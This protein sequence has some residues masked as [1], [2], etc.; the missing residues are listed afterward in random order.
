MFDIIRLIL[1]IAFII[2]VI[3]LAVKSSKITN[4]EE[5]E[6]I[7]QKISDYTAEFN[8]TGT[9]KFDF[10]ERSAEAAGKAS[11]L[12]IFFVL[13]YFI[14][15][16]IFVFVFFK[17]HM[18][19]LMKEFSG[20]MPITIGVILLFAALIFLSHFLHRKDIHDTK[21]IIVYN[22]VLE[23]TRYK[24]PTFTCNIGNTSFSCRVEHSNN[25]ASSFRY[26]DIY[27]KSPE[28]KIM[29][30]LHISKKERRSWIAFVAFLNTLSGKTQ[31]K[32]YKHLIQETQNYRRG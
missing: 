8:A 18:V 1:A 27:V 29:C 3:V 25:S 31:Y 5:L 15:F 24:N 30:S 19:V 23:I 17:D 20:F 10:E 13:G 21:E 26:F 16:F 28:D 11:K 2:F 7:T 12:V 14:V 9:L 32:D 4:A 6:E 22:D